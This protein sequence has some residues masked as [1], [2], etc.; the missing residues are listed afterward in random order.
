M[1]SHAQQKWDCILQKYLDERDEN[2]LITMQYIEKENTG[3][4]EKQARR[5]KFF[6]L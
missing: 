1:C 2:I 5:S 6:K 4:S 3:K